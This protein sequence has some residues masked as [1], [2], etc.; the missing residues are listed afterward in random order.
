MD[1][2][3]V[4]R[5]VADPDYN[6][7]ECPI[8]SKSWRKK[9]RQELSVCKKCPTVV[10]TACLAGGNYQNRCIQCLSEWGPWASKPLF[11]P[12]SESV[13]DKELYGPPNCS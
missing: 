1:A 12:A 3:N 5:E 2:V 13:D 6:S 4:K 10:H 9:S 11:H 7:Y 8:C